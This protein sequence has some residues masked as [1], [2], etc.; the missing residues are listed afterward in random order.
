MTGHDDPRSSDFVLSFIASDEWANAGYVLNES[1]LVSHLRETYGD[2][3]AADMLTR[4]IE[5]LTADLE[6]FRPNWKD[7][8]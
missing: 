1:A 2:G 5:E 6:T 4:L 8:L 3:T 7:N